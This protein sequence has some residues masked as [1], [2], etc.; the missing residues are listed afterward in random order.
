MSP[1]KP[2]AE[3]KRARV[4]EKNTFYFFDN[5]EQERHESHIHSLRE[6]LA[7]LKNRVESRPDEEGKK[8]AFDELLA[9]SENGLRALL[10]LTGFSNESLKRVVTLARICDDRRI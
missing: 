7:R 8:R 3:A 6:T 2:S 1:T 4:I 5:A 10:A 9:Q